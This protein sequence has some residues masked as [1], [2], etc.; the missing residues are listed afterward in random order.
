MQK[1]SYFWSTQQR[2]MWKKKPGVMERILELQLKARRPKR[3]W[4]VLSTYSVPGTRLVSRH[5]LLSSRSLTLTS[6]VL[7][8][9]WTPQMVI[10]NYDMALQNSV[11]IIQ[12][13]MI[14]IFKKGNCYQVSALCLRKNTGKYPQCSCLRRGMTARHIQGSQS[15]TIITSESEHALA[16]LP[17]G[18][19]YREAD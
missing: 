18:K 10:V 15:D 8:Y 7:S 2:G 9:L 16:R 14:W 1:K 19:P 12:I 17:V 3:N 4:K 13:T 11:T 6:L 5:T